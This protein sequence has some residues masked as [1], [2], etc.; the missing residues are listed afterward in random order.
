MPDHILLE[1]VNDTARLPNYPIECYRSFNS[2]YMDASLLHWHFC[3]EMVFVH[4]GEQ[5][6]SIGGTHLTLSAGSCIYIHPRQVHEF[7]NSSP[8]G[9]D[10]TL[11]KFD[12]SLLLSR[13]PYD[14]E[15]QYLR[16]FLPE[17]G[18]RC[19]TFTSA[20]ERVQPHL[21][22]LLREG[23]KHT[24]G[25]E[26][27]MRNSICMLVEELLDSLSAA[28]VNTACLSTQEQEQFNLVLQ[29]LSKHFV[30]EN[31][32]DTALSICNLSYSNFAAKFKRMFGKT[33][34]EY[35]NHVR[36]SN[37]CQML[38]NSSD[39]VAFI[40]EACGYHDAGYFGRMFRKIT[41]LSPQAYRAE[42]ERL[43]QEN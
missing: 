43:R 31:L 38:V 37:A 41:G 19:L 23:E 6:V 34:T 32:M 5:R 16:P 3:C 26:T 39:S 13:T 2:K 27:R 8:D 35:L 22:R 29:Y 40:A 11:L 12:T 25:F 24:F 7:I 18:Y 14:A 42:W 17:S 33:F 15:Q 1:N 28:P 4:H 20:A 36:I 21:D 9:T 30:E 10:L